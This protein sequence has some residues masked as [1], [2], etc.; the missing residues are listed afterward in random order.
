LDQEFQ[1]S[2]LLIKGANGVFEVIVA[3]DLVFSKHSLGR[4]PEDGE[5]AATIRDRS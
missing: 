4:F 3:G 2:T 5:V 1:T